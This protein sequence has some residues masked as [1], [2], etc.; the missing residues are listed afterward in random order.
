MRIG[1]LSPCSRS[2]LTSSRNIPAHL[3][4]PGVDAARRTA[5]SRGDPIR[6]SQRLGRQFVACLKRAFETRSPSRTTL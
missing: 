5:R 4:Q 2:A 6:A 1:S 3:A